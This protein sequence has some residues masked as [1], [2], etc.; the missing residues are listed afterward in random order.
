M[1]MSTHIV[2]VIPPD[3]KWKKMKEIYNNCMDVGIQIPTEVEK[4][5][6]YQEP[7]EVGVILDLTTRGYNPPICRE[8]GGDCQQGFE[9]DVADIPAHVKTLRFYNAY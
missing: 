7:D 4:F 1:S 9:I 3:D 5:F 8:W 6:D 2:G